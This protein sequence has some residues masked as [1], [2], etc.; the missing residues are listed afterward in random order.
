MYRL[1]R[2]SRSSKL[3]KQEANSWELVKIEDIKFIHSRIIL[4]QNRKEKYLQER[5]KLIL[6]DTFAYLVLKN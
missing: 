5:E 1:Y 6:V 2:C 3:T 4:T